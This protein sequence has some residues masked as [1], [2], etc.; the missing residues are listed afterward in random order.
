MCS[1]K[2][3]PNARINICTLHEYKCYQCILMED[4]N[5]LRMSQHI[6]DPLLTNEHKEEQMIISGDLINKADNVSWFLNHIMTGV[7][8]LTSYRSMRLQHGSS[9]GHHDL[10]NTGRIGRKKIM[11]ELIFD[12]KVIV[13]SKFILHG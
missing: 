13:H 1:R 12:S 9:P 3:S 4:L 7:I 10:K 6:I 2:S 11:L 5:M 8:C